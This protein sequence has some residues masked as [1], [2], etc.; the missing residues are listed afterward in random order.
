[1]I[2]QSL[3]VIKSKELILLAKQSFKCFCHTRFLESFYSY[4]VV[5]V[6]LRIKK[7]PCLPIISEDF[8]KSWR[9]AFLYEKICDFLI[10]TAVTYNKVGFCYVY[11]AV[12]NHNRRKFTCC[13]RERINLIS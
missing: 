1:M 13:K 5:P 10:F 6:G 8:D 2:D 11:I 3:H 9:N 12:T 7:T 4:Q